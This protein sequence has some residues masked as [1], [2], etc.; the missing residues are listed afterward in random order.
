MAVKKGG[1]GKGL[2]ALFNE[3]ATDTASGTELNIFEIE[4]NRDQPRKDFDDESISELSESILKHGL[5]QP[6]VV[7]PKPNGR[8]EIVAGERRWRACR[9]A[10]LDSVPVIIKDL[11][12]QK[13]AEIALVEN[14]QRENLNA[15]EEALGYKSLMDDFGLTQE[16]VSQSVGK[17]R[18][19]VTNALRLLNLPENILAALR[20]GKISAGAAR[21]LLSAKSEAIMKAM[22]EAALLGASVRTLEQMAKKEEKPIMAKKVKV[23]SN[24]ERE[25]ALSLKQ[26]LHRNVKITSNGKGKGSITI[27]FYNQEELKDFANRL[28]D[29]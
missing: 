19:A 8:Y 18:V 10:G 1:L 2:D 23:L 14:L 12:G 6:I 27:D 22:F 20:E 28:T 24:F 15:Y 3:N 16:A 4:P 17:S 7:R 25:V 26:A 9:L 29:K 21:T 11:D 5:L 13:A